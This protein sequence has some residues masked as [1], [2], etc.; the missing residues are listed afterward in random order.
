M[1]IFNLF[2]KLLLDTS[3]YEKG[4]DE[5]KTKGNDFA[6]DAQNVVAPKAAIAFGAIATAVVAVA[7][8]M[9]QLWQTTLQ[10]ADTFGDLSAKYGIAT[11]SI[12]EFAYMA[13]QT[14]TEINTLLSAMAMMYNRAKEGDEAFAKIGVSVFEANGQIKQMDELFWECIEAL[15]QIDN[16]GQRSATM[17]D[18]FGRSAMNVGEFLRKDVK[19]LN[20]LKQEAHDF[21]I[22]MKDTTTDFAGGWFDTL[23]GLKM[24]GQSALASLISGDA[25]AEE[26][27]QAFFD[28]VLEIAEDN[29]PTFVNFSIK[30]FVNVVTALIR[31]A[32]TL[33]VEFTTAIASIIFDPQFWLQTAVDLFKSIGEAITNVFGIGNAR[34]LG[35]D[36]DYAN[37]DVGKNLFAEPQDLEVKQSTK[38]EVVV[39]VQAEGETA[40]SQRS[41]ED[42]ARALA[43]ILDEILG[44]V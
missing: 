5:A 13:T 2:A 20:A 40:I 19:E 22:V 37:F 7:R 38:R 11:E 4:L 28:R 29:M 34:F 33:L 21:N 30:L 14:G 18:V 23:D 8:E 31:I 42:T 39:K 26:K 35:A 16:E 6:D 9:Y 25:D 12:S 44:G 43:P 41:A 15:N 32:P 17:L 24:Q 36:I 10:Y 1:N 3:D 27:L